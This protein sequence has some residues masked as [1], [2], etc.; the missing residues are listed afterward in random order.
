MAAISGSYEYHCEFV[1]LRELA[2]RFP[3]MDVERVGISANE[4]PTNNSI[5]ALLHHSD[6]YKVAVIHCLTDP[7]FM[8]TFWSEAVDTAMFESAIDKTP[9]PEDCVESFG[10]KLL[11]IQGIGLG[12]IV[13]P[14]FRLVEALKNANKDFD[15]LCLPKV[16]NQVSSY[17]T[18]R[19]WDYFVTHLQGDIPPKQYRLKISGEWPD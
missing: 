8:P 17:G 5:Y 3:Y 6:F 7:R 9:Y 11:L 14:A 1:G 16:N 18:R 19:E 12:G 10:G 15:M 2:K 4:N 13:A